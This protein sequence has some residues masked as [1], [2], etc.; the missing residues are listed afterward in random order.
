MDVIEAMETCSAARYLKPDPVPQEM[1]E[2]VIYAATRASSPGNS[3]QWDFIVVRNPEAKQKIRDLLVPRFK[4]MRA[5]A[6]TG[7]VT[8]RMIDGAT[9]LA[10]TLNEV[11]AIIFVCGPVA[12]PPNAPMEQFVWSALYPAAQNLIVAAR[13]LGLGTT[14]TT[15][16]MFME[17]ELHELLGIP[18]EIKFGV[19]IPIGWPQNDFV[20]VKRKEIASVIHWDKWSD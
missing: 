14:F 2:R 7:R 13:S 5:G 4:A 19:M 9:H 11:P 16:H 12:Y 6:Q 10:E 20:K 8:S 17:T 15:F 3:Q 18:K 1:I